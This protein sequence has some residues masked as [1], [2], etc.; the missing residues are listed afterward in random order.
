[1]GTDGG[2]DPGDAFAALGS[3]RRISILRA[4]AEAAEAE[5]AE[6][7]FTGLYD[8]LAIDS[9][10]QLSYH[11]DQL[12][13]GFVRKSGDTYTLTQAGERVL[14]AI[15]SGTYDTEPVFDPITVE[16]ACPSCESSTLS[17]SYGD[18]LLTVAC[19]DCDATVVTYDL[20]PSATV[21]RTSEEILASCDLRARNDLS[22]A[23]EGTCPTCGGVMAVS[24]EATDGPAEHTC[25]TDCEQCGLRLFAPLAAR[26]LS[27]PGVVAFFWK[28]DVDVMDWPFWRL[29]SL[30]E[31]WEVTPD[32]PE[33]VPCTVTVRHDGEELVARVEADLTTTIVSR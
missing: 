16:G 5:E 18:R 6:L 17:V 8:R 12:T 7:S 23:L 24:V 30:I 27:H 31:G 21:D 33:S 26:L 19:A 32:G 3:E 1:M 4:L 29:L 13:D 22:V 25:R 10:S 15:R 9:T 14:R 28:H 20:P 11:L 2:T